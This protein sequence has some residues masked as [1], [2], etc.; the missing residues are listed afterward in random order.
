MSYR[1]RTAKIRSSKRREVTLEE[2]TFNVRTTASPLKKKTQVQTKEFG[3]ASTGVDGQEEG[4]K[5][6][7]RLTT[8]SLKKSK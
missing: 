3:G 4:T 6:D 2:Q 1:E 8:A 5:N 7:H